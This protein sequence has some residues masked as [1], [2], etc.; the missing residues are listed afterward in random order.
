MKLTHMKLTQIL[1]EKRSLHRD[2][3]YKFVPEIIC[4]NC[5][6]KSGKHNGTNFLCPFENNK[7]SHILFKSIYSYIP[8]EEDDFC[9][10]SK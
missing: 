7:D 6:N 3:F 10:K 2:I 4:V 8:N 1:S 9:F 5:N